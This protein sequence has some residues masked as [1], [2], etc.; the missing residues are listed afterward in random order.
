MLN[1]TRD[2]EDRERGGVITH[3]RIRLNM[4]EGGGTL[5]QKKE[6]A[7]KVYLCM[8]AELDHDRV[9]T[10][11]LSS[12]WPERR[13]V[14]AFCARTRERKVPAVFRAVTRRL[15]HRCPVLVQIRR[16]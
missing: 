13:S 3:T 4:A 8:Y 16:C 9:T 12:D 1:G 11:R 2:V 14:M 7:E 6:Y 15:D 5:R 10:G